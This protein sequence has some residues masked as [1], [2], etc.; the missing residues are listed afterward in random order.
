MT[1]RKVRMDVR[2]DNQVC[3]V[4]GSAR[5]IGYAVAEI[6]VDS[7]AKVAMVDILADRLA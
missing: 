2:F 4:T 7:G 5:G 6:L 1:M 3:V